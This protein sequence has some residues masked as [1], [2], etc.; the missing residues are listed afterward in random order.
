M[1]AREARWGVVTS[2]SRY[3][4]AYLRERGADLRLS[5]EVS[6]D[7]AAPAL[8]NLA[9]YAA[10]ESQRDI[11]FD[12][13]DE[14]LVILKTGWEAPGSSES[15]GNSPYLPPPSLQASAA[16]PRRSSQRLNPQSGRQA[17]GGLDADE[18]RLVARENRFV[19]G[20]VFRR[21][22]VPA[23]PALGLP[24]VFDIVP[25]FETVRPLCG[26][27]TPLARSD[28]GPRPVWRFLVRPRIG[29]GG[30]GDVF[31]GLELSTGTAAALKVCSAKDA[32][33]RREAVFYQAAVEPL[34]LSTTLR[35]HGFFQSAYLSL[36]V[37]ELGPS[38]IPSFEVLT[39][40]QRSA[41]RFRLSLS[42]TLTRHFSEQDE[43]L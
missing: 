20:A 26:D 14:L 42:F 41:P 4:I 12:H 21:A 1:A 18:I 30:T 32:L 35:F 13:R 10:L 2:G 40:P 38:A 31:A 15:D 25:R 23:L 17:S 29:R 5:D 6:I 28:R 37:L 43:P 33:I 24:S 8:L 39:L 3:R 34:G 7:S 27:S 19:T 22:I 16:Q 36:L 11:S 9:V